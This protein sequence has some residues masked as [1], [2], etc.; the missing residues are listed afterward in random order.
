MAQIKKTPDRSSIFSSLA[1]SLVRR[2]FFGILILLAIIWMSHLGFN[3]AQG[4]T[5]DW[6]FTAA[7]KQM[8]A[9]VQDILFGN[10]GY[11]QAGTNTRTPF[12]VVVIAREALVR[13]LGLLAVSL[14]LAAVTGIFLGV[15]SALWR[16]SSLSLAILM[17]T[18]A[19]V[20]LPSFFAALIFQIIAIK[21]S[22]LLPGGRSFLPVGGFGWDT[23]LV[24]PA[25][26]LAARPLAQITRM[27]FLTVKGVLEKDYVRTAYAKGVRQ[28]RVIYAHVLQ[29]SMI[30]ILTTVGVSVRFA[31]SS[32]PVVER[33][34]GWRGAGDMLLVGIFNRERN[35]AILLVVS[36]GLIFVV[37]NMVLDLLYKVI[38]PRLRQ[39]PD[40]IASHH[41][42]SIMEWLASLP[43]RFRMWRQRQFT[44]PPLGITADIT[45]IKEA[46]TDQVPENDPWFEDARQR[47][48]KLWLKNTL[49]NFSLVLGGLILLSLLGM[50][51]FGPEISPMDPF[52]IRE[53]EYRDGVLSVPP[54]TPNQEFVLG[55]DTVGRDILSLILVGV[56]PTMT[57]AVIAAFA[58]LVVGFVLGALAGWMHG[59]KFDRFLLGLAETIS[60]YPTLVLAMILIVGLDIRQG[61]KP[62]I[63]ALCVVGWGEVMQYVRAEVMAIRTK[64]YIEA[65][66]AIGQR[67][68]RILTHQVFPNLIPGLISLAALEMGAVLMILGELGFLQIFINGVPRVDINYSA[69]PEWGSLLATT[70]VFARAYPWTSFYPALAFFAAIFGFNLFGEGIRRM[71][72][73][74]GVRINKLFNR[75]TLA[76]V[77]LFF[78]VFFW[79]RGDTGALVFY[80]KNAA[81]FNGVRAY[82]HVIQLSGPSMQ[83][84]VLGS[85]GLNEAADYIADQ[86]RKNHLQAAGAE[87]SFYQ[88]RARDYI[89][90]Q[91]KPLMRIDDDAGELVL[92]QDYSVFPA[93]VAVNQGTASGRVRAIVMGEMYTAY[94][95]LGR[96]YSDNILLVT[97]PEEYWHIRNTPKAGVLVVADD[98]ALFRK[99]YTLTPGDLRTY[100][101]GLSSAQDYPVMWISEAAAD[102][103]LAGSGYSVA[104]IR[105]AKEEMG[106]GEIMEIPAF[107]QV[108][109]S[110]RGD[111]YQDVEVSNVIGHWQ[112]ESQISSEMIMVLAQYDRPPGQA[113]ARPSGFND[114]ASGVGLMLETLRTMVDTGYQPHRTILFVGYSSE[115]SE[116]WQRVEPSVATFLSA[117]PGFDVAYNVVAVI[118]LRGLGGGTGEE[119]LLQSSDER[120]LSVFK[121][122]A[123]QLGLKVKIEDQI[124]NFNY[125]VTPTHG[126]EPGFQ[127]PALGLSYAGWAESARTPE[128]RLELVSPGKLRDVG[129]L[130]TLSLMIIG[131]EPDY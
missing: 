68:T 60:A 38:D 53:I 49:G 22:Q 110:A 92:G 17:A 65:A 129:E 91:D 31:L 97:S 88:L 101:S 16:R 84:R 54:F 94:Q 116:R 18:L 111:L 61:M 25:L 4:R 51:L 74:V 85:E 2:I 72:E 80:K 32:L 123:R 109:L 95:L 13:S 99:E 107:V 119:I 69:V 47:E 76:G 58:R 42:P 45:P 122:T 114:N 3:M 98:P 28:R 108:T 41:T 78:A 130:L 20:S 121:K 79:Y 64:P 40:H 127:V 105:S 62:F 11:T 39:T 34:F 55:S 81:Q 113:G 21:M 131:R 9:T 52:V 93:A 106:P 117:K 1:Y 26:V 82:E 19:G 66:V 46:P 96:D 102:R 5:F 100:K 50:Y 14:S 125:Y 73:N 59:G 126:L 120:I 15:V 112:A 43:D 48:R 86:F 44:P 7:N 6:S 124:G 103:V 30:T 115:G 33:Y 71:I 90:L 77:V 27:T 23:H 87:L 57:L 10:L 63:I 37:V 128:D 75:Y 89:L 8:P 29:N 35:L 36:F 70:R 56:Q 67:F 104:R 118:D 12:P 83:G 24:L